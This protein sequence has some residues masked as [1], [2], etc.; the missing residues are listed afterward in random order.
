MRFHVAVRGCFDY[1]CLRRIQTCE[2]DRILIILQSVILYSQI[3][4][5]D[6]G[7]SEVSN[8]QS[9]HCFSSHYGVAALRSRR[10][11]HDSSVAIERDMETDYVAAADLIKCIIE[12]VLAW[13]GISC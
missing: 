6:G 13:G 11:L 1:Y 12:R 3:K 8:D 10:D 2:N 5:I 4:P 9:N 7:D